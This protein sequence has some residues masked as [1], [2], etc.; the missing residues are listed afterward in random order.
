MA[1]YDSGEVTDREKSAAQR[2]KEIA[3]YNKN[4]LNDVAQY[5]RDTA[6]NIADWSMGQQNQ[7]SNANAANTNEIAQ[8]NALA[9][10]GEMQ[11]NLGNYD[12]ADRQNAALR[13][14]Q[15]KQASR[16]S[17]AERFEAQRNLRN[18]ALGL[19]G[20]MNQAMNGSTTGNA[21]SMLRDRNDADNS[22]Y[23]QNL[24]DN[25]NS[26]QNA[27]NE[28]V[29]QNNV[30]RRDAAI[31]A[32][33]A[34][35]DIQGDLSSNLN[36]IQD[37]F[38]AN[39]TNIRGDLLTNLGNNWGDLYANRRNLR[40]DLAANLNN[41]NPSLYKNPNEKMADGLDAFN[42]PSGGYQIPGSIGSIPELNATLTGGAGGGVG[43]GTIYRAPWGNSVISGYERQANDA[44]NGVAENRSRLLDY[45]MPENAEQDVV[46]RRNRLTGNS[47]FDRLVNGYNN[48]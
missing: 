33:K 40:G 1:D 13:D 31:N 36:N 2:Q 5:N 8:Y 39:I 37:D 20:S 44:L 15:F 46:G 47:Y 27:Y 23:W 41:I 19:F 12:F 48:R 10:I 4:T 28:S 42:V 24:Q 45:I 35:H 34:I 30:A 22:T 11:R 7:I 25:Y 3:N 26:I 43:G 6:K 17:E 38:L 32:I 16:K 21:M 9:T 29:N 18:A 14:T